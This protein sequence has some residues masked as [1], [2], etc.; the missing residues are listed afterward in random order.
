MTEPKF[1]QADMD[2]VSDS[3]ELT[4]ADMAA[5]VPFDQ[6]F[7]KMAA[8]IRRGRGPQKAPRKELTTIRLSPDVIA[9]FK[10]AGQG[11]QS[12]IDAALKDWMAGHG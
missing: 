9:H 12:R 10:R 5:A 8:A 11:W 6:A 2:A 3:P 4:A 7:P 1:T